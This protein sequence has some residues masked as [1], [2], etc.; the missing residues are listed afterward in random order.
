[1]NDCENVIIYTIKL[2]EKSLKK[3]LV[4]GTKKSKPRF[5]CKRYIHDFTKTTEK[6]LKNILTK[7]NKKTL[8][9]KHL[10]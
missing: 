3:L 4:Y 8:K 10:S 5:M 6:I 9:S 1:M 2:T 7:L